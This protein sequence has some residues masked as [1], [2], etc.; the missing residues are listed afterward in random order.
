MSS[1]T[2]DHGLGSLSQSARTEGLKSAR[3]ILYVVGVITI[4]ANVIFAFLTKSMVNEEFNKEAAKL[5]MQGMV[6]DQVELQALKDQT[7]RAAMLINIGGIVLGIVF[8]ILG[9]NVYKYPVVCTITGL[10]LY[11]GGMA[12]FGYLEPMSLARGWIVKLIII[13]GLF[14]AI[15]TAIAYERE[16]RNTALADMPAALMD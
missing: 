1:V 4:V 12:V 9:A 7:T 10:V 2:A 13:I 15:K 14:K 16:E 3:T 8:L 6:I 11:L 5:Q